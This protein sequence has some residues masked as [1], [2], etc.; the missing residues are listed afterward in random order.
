M[1]NPTHEYKK[2]V[3]YKDPKHPDQ[4]YYRVRYKGKYT[5]DQIKEFCQS[6]SNY[7]HEKSPNSAFITVSLRFSERE[8]RSGPR[9]KPSQPVA[10]W[11]PYDSTVDPTD[12]IIGFDLLFTIPDDLG[13][14]QIVDNDEEK[15]EKEEKEFKE[16]K[17]EKEVKKITTRRS[18]RL[19]NKKK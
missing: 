10:I 12:Q 18:Q 9:T 17:E 14:E 7:L 19:L 2:K 16:E 5:R 4:S 1:I 13:E 15:E 11:M 3:Q 8:F 6:K